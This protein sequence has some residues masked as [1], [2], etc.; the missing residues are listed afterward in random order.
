M[1]RSKKRPSQTDNIDLSYTVK[2]EGTEVHLMLEQARLEAARVLRVSPDSL[3]ITSHTPP[4]P[5]KYTPFRANL[6]VPLHVEALAMSVSF[7]I[8][9]DVNLDEQ[10][11]EAGG[12]D[13]LDEG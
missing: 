13:P 1:P 10:S 2:V 8:K 7:K 12:E 4:Q 9:E 3:F 6:S 5:S 11:T